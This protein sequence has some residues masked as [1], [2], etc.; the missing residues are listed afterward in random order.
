MKMHDAFIREIRDVRVIDGDT[1]TG[2]IRLGFGI[3]LTH[4]VFR[5]YGIN[6]YET[7]RRGRWDNELPEE[8]V[9]SKIALGKAGKTRLDE[10]VNA[11]SAITI[12][13]IVSPSARSR[14]GKFGRWL[15]NLYIEIEGSIIHWNEVLVDEGYGYEK[16][17]D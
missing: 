17:Y 12:K 3:E 15:V 7:T 2:C 11:A 4:Q 6:A 8:E 14:S 13:S 1:I 5:L 9:Q 10:L 16:E